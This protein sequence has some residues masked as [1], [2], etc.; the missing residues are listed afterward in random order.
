MVFQ[1]KN[2]TLVG[3]IACQLILSKTASSPELALYF[4]KCGTRG[5]QKNGLHLGALECQKYWWGQASAVGIISPRLEPIQSICQNLVG[6][7]PHVPIRSVGHVH[8]ICLM[9]L[10]SGK[11]PN[12]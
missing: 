1:N 6:T 2:Y 9:L 10:A 3:T 8:F 7:S 11:Q 4:D 12:C 5:M